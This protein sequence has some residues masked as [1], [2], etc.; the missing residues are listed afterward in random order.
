[1]TSK[2]KLGDLIYDPEVE[3]YEVIVAKR[4]N[5]DPDY[6]PYF[7]YLTTIVDSSKSTLYN[8]GDFVNWIES[9]VDDYYLRIGNIM[10]KPNEIVY[11]IIPFKGRWYVCENYTVLDSFD[12]ERKAKNYL[13]AYKK[14][15]R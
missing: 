11:K 5:G 1:M 14:V 7:R 9:T 13:E 10:N 3:V 15:M 6:H 4:L 12:S 2:Y 8:D